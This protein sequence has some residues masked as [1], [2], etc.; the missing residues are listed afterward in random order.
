MPTPRTLVAAAIAAAASTA[1]A[2]PVKSFTFAMPPLELN[3]L[4]GS[5]LLQGAE[6]FA[7]GQVI[8]AF[9]D[10]TLIVEEAPEGAGFT[11]SAAFFT[12][13]IVLPV[14]L[15]GDPDDIIA[16]GVG[17]RGT[18]LGWEG[19]GRFT[20]RV[21]AESAIGG[22]FIVPFLFTAS[23]TGTLSAT[24]RIEGRLQEATSS[25]TLIV[26]RSS[27]CTADY[28]GDGAATTDDIQLFMDAY[29]AGQIEADFNQDGIINARDLSFFLQTLSRECTRTPSKS[30]PAGAGNFRGATDTATP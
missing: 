21:P 12:T 5:S 4:L 29:L 24:E 30:R 26:A 6:G 1:A 28:N 20:A 2:Q 19:A 11:S 18:D 23:T 10:I 16:P 17:V 3:F 25:W 14:N 13:D 9:A 22:T 7:G 8:D 27:G 15:S